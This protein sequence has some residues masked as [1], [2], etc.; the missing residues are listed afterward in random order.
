[1]GSPVVTNDKISVGEVNDLGGGNF[2]VCLT[3]EGPEAAISQT[4]TVSADDRDAAVQVAKESFSRWLKKA[5]QYVVK[6]MPT[7]MR[8]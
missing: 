8:N 7:R 2:S 5:T 1:M 3:V 6:N 4:Q